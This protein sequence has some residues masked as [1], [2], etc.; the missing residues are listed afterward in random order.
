[1]SKI[2]KLR[3]VNLNYNSNTIKINDEIFY[4]NSESTL[5]NLRN[6]GGKSVL[7]QMMMAP[8]VRG[9]YRAL[10]ER[11]FESY[12]TTPTPTYILVEW[13][14][15]HEAGYLLTGMMV[16]KKDTSSD[17]N[18]K[19][20]LDIVNFVH[21]Y[22]YEN[23]F[24][25]KNINIVEVDG[26]VKKVKSFGNTK[27]LFES[28]KKDK[29]LKFNYYD[30]NNSNT[31]KGYFNK[32]LEY[33]IN[34]KEWEEIIKKINIEESGLSKLF[35]GA[36]DTNGLLK[37]W[38]IPNVEK[39]I[40]KSENKDES[41]INN[42]RT[43][44]GSYV[45]Q[46]KENKANIDKKEKIKR[47]E[48]LS[49]NLL[50][51]A[52][53]GILNVIEKEKLENI[54][55]NMVLKLSK[56]IEVREIN[57]EDIEK[58]IVDLK[59][60]IENLKYERL[61]IEIHDKND[62][63]EKLEKELNEVSE[64]IGN[65]KNDELEVT[66]NKNIL[67]CAKLNEN[68]TRFSKK[69]QEVE[70]KLEILRKQSAESQGEISNLGYSLN[71]IT[72]LELEKLEEELLVMK[73]NKNGLEN[74]EREIDENI[75]ANR[76]HLRTLERKRGGLEAQKEGF[77]NLESAFNNKYEY[78]LTRNIEGLIHDE[79]FM[80]VNDR[81][82]DEETILDKN[83]K[84][85]GANLLT[86]NREKKEKSTQREL[87][88]KSI[89]E[90]AVKLDNK[91]VFLKELN[92]DLEVR[93]D[94]LK[95]INFSENKIFESQ[96]IEKEF[97]LKL[98]K[99]REDINLLKSE[100]ISIEKEINKLNTGKVIEIP[101][102]IL[103]I[104]KEKSIEIIYGLEWL[105][106]NGNSENENLLLVKNNPFIPYSLI[107]ERRDIEV[108]GNIELD[109]FTS[110]PIVII[111]REELENEVKE[112]I[113]KFINLSGINFLVAFNNRLLN[114]E[115]LL[116]IIN[117]KKEKVKKLE[118]K[119]KEKNEG[120]KLY[121]EKLTII[122]RSRLSLEDYEKTQ[123]EVEDL[124]LELKNLKEK[125]LYL[126]KEISRIQVESVDREKVLKTLD[127]KKIENKKKIAALV[128]FKE[129]Y[130][131]YL[132]HKESLS[133]TEEKIVLI[134]NK[135][136]DDNFERRRVR[137]LLYESKS[138]ISTYERNIEDKKE[139]ILKYSS[140]KEG[141]Y[142]KKD[143]ED[144]EAK[145]I[146]L[147]SE[148]T[149]TEKELLKERNI[150]DEDFR[151]VRDE[152]I[153]YADKYKLEQ[154]E[155]EK[156]IYSKGKVN[157]I[158]LK[159]EELI[160]L[161]EKLK[162]KEKEIEKLIVK[163]E[164]EIKNSYK[165]LKNECK[166]DL[167]KEKKNLTKKNFEDEIS[168]LKEEVRKFEIEVE[169]QKEERN[170]LNRNL[171]NLSDF[172]DLK[173]VEE[174]DIKID[175]N[176]ITDKVKNIRKEF[177]GIKDK[178]AENARILREEV[179]EIESDKAFKDELFFREALRTLKISNTEAKIFKEQLNTILDSYRLI[180]GKL[181]A[182][183]ESIVKEE[184]KIIAN[185]LEYIQEVDLNIS[186][187][188]ENST[189]DIEGK[190]RKMLEI[191]TLEFE[192]RK[193]NYRLK[194]KS[195]IENIRN[196]GILILEKNENIEDLLSKTITTVKLYDEV[197]GIDEIKI[198][199]FKVEE[200]RQKKITWKEVATN[201]GGE[202]FLSAFVILTSLLSYIR[203]DENDIFTKNEEGKV[204][205][206]DNPFAQTNASH[207]LKPLMDIAKKNN[208]QL[209][210]L[211]GLG[212]ESIYNRFDNI[213]VLN[214]KGSSV[215]RGIQNLKVDH[216]QGEEL[217]GEIIPSR[218]KIEEQ[219]RLF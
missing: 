135:I 164:T 199:L 202:G 192:P 52:E 180:V 163:V 78:K 209:I 56:E 11:T 24:D 210:C 110:N 147:T 90:N 198:N 87:I 67:E 121:D 109:F 81:I 167:I 204:L 55:K 117:S 159:L 185:L 46:Y 115:E 96:E 98:A 219:T 6:G 104:L 69:L 8:F 64:L 114:E 151:I 37:E 72:N 218:F 144:L 213:Y 49:V 197:I 51:V 25:I 47:F 190:K 58:R 34:N 59:S 68:Q 105:K 20:K 94:L 23:E 143:K 125:G 95:F 113:G 139:E 168:K 119:I 12:F 129:N 136:N 27:K 82:L 187:I 22:R 154:E 131:G 133:E 45:K 2:N 77:D 84:E 128:E 177:S 172:E 39:K 43:I 216:I 165:I 3:I 70:I 108:L 127:V 15:E 112:K 158:E 166:K 86:L 111:A 130:Q 107:M 153:E 142:L 183:I 178:I 26:G 179:L 194:L 150:A 145:F 181:E 13:K 138:S 5:L 9:R 182:D 57:K 208:T 79:D 188:D 53:E 206:M 186:K 170:L 157:E 120:I 100:K 205:V 184:E 85:E 146:A 123:T 212:G 106:K 18:S 4:F 88:I 126:E 73:N 155:Y 50:K 122:K 118:S 214:L 211:T 7:V 103:N 124:T 116:N 217:E 62:E 61:S 40:D 32:L 176:E 1:M 201:S 169:E 29:K 175:I 99:I 101:E 74:K 200:N 60:E 156:E 102:E 195:Y 36:K 63:K 162:D 54:I 141:E 80:L 161:G 42:Y 10:G 171:L 134:N 17:E 173:L 193:E 191:I 97:E 89:N 132:N 16:R 140:Y 83:I 137:E 19:E 76:N 35:T 207:L 148:I 93:K 21:E 38:F 196:R 30:M 33:G 48:E 66:K 203:R 174:L 91:K 160:K 41:R 92:D 28:L 215:Q 44:V 189:I 152:L 31:R 65:N 71:K 14:L 75:E 149:K